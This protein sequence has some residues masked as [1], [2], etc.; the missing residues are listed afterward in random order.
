MYG[1]GRY[2]LRL[3]FVALP[4][5]A[6]SVASAT[7]V[8]SRAWVFDRNGQL[9]RVVRGPYEG[10]FTTSPVLVNGV[11][12]LEARG[13]ASLSLATTSAPV[14]MSVSQTVGVGD[15]V[16]AGS[17]VLGAALGPTAAIALAVAVPAFQWYLDHRF[18]PDGS[19]GVEQD[20]GSPPVDYY[21]KLWRCYYGCGSVPPAVGSGQ[22]APRN[23]CGTGQV[24]HIYGED[25]NQ[26]A[27]CRNSDGS[28]SGPF[29]EMYQP[30]DPVKR[31]IEVSSGSSVNSGRDGRCP[32]G[33]YESRSPADVKSVHDAS[34]LK[35]TGAAAASILSRLLADGKS[36][37]G[38]SD[39]KV[40]GPSSSP[41][42]STT[43]TETPA[44]T[45][46]NPNPVPRTTTTTTTN[47]YTYQGDTVTHNTTITTVINEGDT[48]IGGDTTT[49]TG[50]GSQPPSTTCKDNP[51]A[52]GCLDVGEPPSGESV[53]SGSENMPPFSDPGLLSQSACPA[54]IVVSTPW[55]FSVTF[56]FTPVCDISRD[57]L[58]PIVLVLSSFAALSVFTRSFMI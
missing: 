40:S 2:L 49:T 20:P 51:R 21:G 5:L 9:S 14:P 12:V 43:K 4:L 1:L 26:A 35:L 10:T 8:T 31:C 13:T 34:T 23:Y 52:L 18:R 24:L 3:C 54:P 27:Y 32:T 53:P 7:P 55:G 45:A 33:R 6:V 28:A 39:P 37:E 58:A 42:P 15:V 44:P 11:E 57:F 30:I 16:A 47:N 56:S 29:W 36:V 17:S 50:G 25:G 19:G 46:S 38:G 41:G 48:I 22:S